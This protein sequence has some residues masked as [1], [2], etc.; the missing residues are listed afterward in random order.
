MKETLISLA[1]AFVLLSAMP[2]AAQ[3]G[4]K[5]GMLSCQMAPSVGLIVG[6]HQHIRCRFTPDAGGPLKKCTPALSRALASM[7]E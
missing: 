5:A 7:S 3:S 6:S 1:A 2:A 4:T